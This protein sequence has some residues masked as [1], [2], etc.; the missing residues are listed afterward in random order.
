MVQCDCSQ[1]KCVDKVPLSLLEQEVELLLLETRLKEEHLLH[2]VNLSISEGPANRESLLQ[3]VKY[4]T[5]RY[6]TPNNS[7]T[8]HL[9]KIVV[10]DY[11][12]KIE[13][14]FT[15]CEFEY[16]MVH[17]TNDSDKKFLYTTY[18]VRFQTTE[19]GPRTQLLALLA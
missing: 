14:V 18:R 12:R 6:S 9:Y 3:V 5:G 7:E 17:L 13:K 11:Y 8:K 19:N 4:N 2:F 10:T 15:G 16:F 1:Q